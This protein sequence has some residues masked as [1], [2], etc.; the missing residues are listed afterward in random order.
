M[1]TTDTLR[2]A[3]DSASRI[4]A[5]LAK[6]ISCYILIVHTSVPRGTGTA[7]FLAYS[8]TVGYPLTSTVLGADC[9]GA[10]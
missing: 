1:T 3:A 8:C 6:N 2:T 9:G 7:P 4:L 5:P 10:R